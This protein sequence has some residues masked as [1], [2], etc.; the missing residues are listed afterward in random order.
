MSKVTFTTELVD[1]IGLLGDVMASF[2][3]EQVD[4]IQKRLEDKYPNAN[5]GMAWKTISKFSTLEGTKI[6]MTQSE[7]Q[8]QLEYPE[9]QLDLVLGLFEK[10]RILR[11]ADGIY[12]IAHDTL[13]LQISQKRSGEEKA[14]LEV[15]KLLTDRYAAYV[16]T[17]ALMG[18]KEID[19]INPYRSRLEMTEEQSDFFK[20]SRNNVRKRRAIILGALIAAF[21]IISMFAVYALIQQRQ[22]LAAKKEAI[23]NAK[24][25]EKNAEEA[26]KNAEEARAAEKIAEAAVVKANEAAR[27]AEEE[28]A[29]AEE[30]AK[31]AEREK[32]KAVAAAK[33]AAEAREDAEEKRKAA[34][35]AE[36]AAEKAAEEAKRQQE[37][38]EEAEEAAEKAAAEAKRQQEIA[39]KLRIKGLSTALAVK[40]SNLKYDD[41]LKN[42]LAMKAFSLH[43]SKV[44][45]LISPEIYTGLHDAVGNSMPQGFDEI[46]KAHN[47]AIR[48]LIT[49][50]DDELYSAGS[51]GTLK[52]WSLSSWKDVG[53]P[54]AQPTNIKTS[55]A[56]DIKTTISDNGDWIALGGKKSSIELYNTKN[57]ISKKIN[58]HTG[59]DVYDLAF[60]PDNKQLFTVGADKKIKS[61]DIESGA[62]KEIVSLT[63]QTE[64]ISTSQDGKWLAVGSNSGLLQLY[65][66]NNYTQPFFEDDLNTKITALTFDKN[67]QTLAVG[68]SNGGVYIFENKNNSYSKDNKLERK[69][70][71]QRISTIKFK[72]Y[73]SNEASNVIAIGSYD[74]TVSV[75]A[76]DEFKDG[77]YDPLILQGGDQKWVMS[78]DF[79]NEGKQLAVGYLGGKIKF[80]PLYPVNLADKLCEIIAEKHENDSELTDDEFKHYLGEDI[81]RK[82][83]TPY[84]KKD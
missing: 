41:R 44:K 24:I 64:V 66:D 77:Q 71:G 9:N 30:A 26:R 46:E 65:K 36:A 73:G 28:K 55:G 32:A 79:V 16:Q 13:A 38:A 84:C 8:A 56:I 17:G 67:T 31:V 25:A 59:K 43:A 12:E 74:G 48:S 47:G 61:Y 10:A 3:E 81:E 7:I 49:T 29:K 14:L 21:A 58:L 45:G 22:A 34:E 33:I 37:I 52:K 60:S 57:K 42:L 75:W 35:A 53:K 82:S 40:S 15:K 69:V 1:R 72:K 2:L 4:A 5:E 27:I 51:D 54:A 70:Q 18:R 76:L 11:L 6:P 50:G 62:I 78:L 20:K 68:L 80:W 19:Y 63:S 23:E 39:E 83:I